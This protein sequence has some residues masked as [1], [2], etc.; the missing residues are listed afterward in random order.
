[1]IADR[2]ENVNVYAGLAD[3]AVIRSGALNEAPH[4]STPPRAFMRLTHFS[5]AFAH[6]FM[7]ATLPRSE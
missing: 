5:K 1:M 3:I 7:L 6:D 2:C 4:S